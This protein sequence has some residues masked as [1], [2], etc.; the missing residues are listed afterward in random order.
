LL[1]LGPHNHW[2]VEQ[3]DAVTSFLEADI[4]EEIF[5]RQHEGFRHTGS[6]GKELV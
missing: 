1:A 3:L 5:M 4:V 6:K 2:E